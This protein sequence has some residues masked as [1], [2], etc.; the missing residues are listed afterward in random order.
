MYKRVLLKISGEALSSDHAPLCAETIDRTAAM[1]AELQRR[2]VEIGIVVGGGNIM[3]GRNAGNMERNRADH[4]GMLSTAI[5]AIA[6][7]DAVERLGVPCTV[8]SAIAMNRFC[9]EY[10]ARDAHRLLAEG[11]VVIFACGTG[12]PFFSTDTGASLRAA[13]IHADV[14]LLAKNIDAVYSTDPK[15]DSTAT[16]YSHLTY[17]RVIAENLQATDITAITMCKEQHIPIHVFALSKTLD[18]FD[19][20]PTGT[21]IDDG[22]GLES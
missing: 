18:V 19:G 11:S 22:I 13:E 17:D 4:M 10:T 12:S 9:P 1:V 20:E 8:L 21:V 3:R 6:L 2:G 7:Q 5:N 14:L 15:T 16:K